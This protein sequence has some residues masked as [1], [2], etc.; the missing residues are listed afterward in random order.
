MHLGMHVGRYV[1][2]K[3]T[4]I[5][6]QGFVQYTDRTTCSSVIT[7]PDHIK[8]ATDTNENSKG[9]MQT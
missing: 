2:K 7:Y 4:G 8:A 5:Q 9:S 6:T 1:Y 3:R